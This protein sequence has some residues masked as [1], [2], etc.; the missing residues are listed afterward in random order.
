MIGVAA[1]RSGP[2]VICV[3]VLV[4]STVGR[5]ATQAQAQDS[6]QLVARWLDAVRTH[7]PG[8][9]DDSIQWL[10]SLS[11]EPWARLNA[12]IKHYFGQLG[13]TGAVSNSVIERAAMLHADAAMF[14]APAPAS[15]YGEGGFTTAPGTLV[16]TVDGEAVDTTDANWHW[17]L[18]RQLLSYITPEPRKVPFVGIWYHAVAA[19]MMQNRLYGEVGAHLARADST[20]P[21]DAR[22]LFDR[23][24]LSEALGLPRSQAAI[25]DLRAKQRAG[26]PMSGPLF[27]P[28]QVP[29]GDRSGLPSA[30]DANSE[31]ERLFRRTLDVDPRFVEARVRLARLLEDRGKFNDADIALRTALVSREIVPDPMLSYYAQLFA[32]RASR[33]LHQLG[34]A[35]VHVRSAL[36]L[37]PNAQSAIIARSELALASGDLSAALVPLRPLELQAE[38]ANRPDPWWAYDQGPGRNADRALADLRAAAAALGR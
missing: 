37:F 7:T 10:G 3:A 26:K 20:L 19:Y 16:R 18:A 24:C 2:F 22:I 32:A 23:A 33:G 30:D 34:P 35:I 12:G 27:I 14:G 25:E 31:A 6:D 38:A 29:V 21:N 8:K 15:R 4:I 13:A 11:V 1:K 36:S 28:G 9:I 17:I 5:P